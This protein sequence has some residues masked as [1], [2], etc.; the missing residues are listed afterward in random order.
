[1]KR[2]K[3]LALVIGNIATG[4]TTFIQSLNNRKNRTIIL[5]DNYPDVTNC[6]LSNDIY[7]ALLNDKTVILEGNYLDRHIRSQ[8]INPVKS[9][10]GNVK[11]ICFDFG[12]GNNE[13][14]KRR[15]Q[16]TISNKEKVIEVHNKYFS[17]YKK[18]ILQEGFLKIIKCY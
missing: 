18:P 6:D 10:I 16:N 9:N 17:Q 1:M 15:L 12:P 8:V 7:E 11:F 13:T 5:N 14:L 2:D 4:K 3:L